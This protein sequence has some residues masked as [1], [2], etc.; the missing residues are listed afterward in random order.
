[1]TPNGWKKAIE[2]SDS[3]QNSFGFSKIFSKEDSPAEY[4]YDLLEVEDTHSFFANNILVHNCILLDEFAFVPDNIA[5]EFF[6]S[7]YPVISAGTQTKIIIVSTPK[8]MN[9]FYTMWT[10]ATKGMSDYLP[11]EV[12]Y[13]A[14]PGRDEKW[15]EETI[16]NTSAVQ[17]QQE[18]ECLHEDTT[19]E[20][21]DEE[22]GKIEKMTIGQLFS[23]LQSFLVY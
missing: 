3:L 1:M 12:H 11:I 23:L 22:T 6:T 5:E 2:C 14:V 9:H 10:K 16:R 21:L 18:F 15:R 17:F 4:V 13:S 19:L 7:T 8:G 20:V